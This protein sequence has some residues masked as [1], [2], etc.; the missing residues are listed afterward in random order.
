MDTVAPELLPIKKPW[1]KQWWF[2]VLVIILGLWLVFPWFLQLFGYQPPASNGFTALPGATG[3]P[4]QVVN[5][6][7][8]DDPQIGFSA[9]PVTIVEFGDFECP[10]CKQEAP[11]L[12]QLLSNYPDTIKIIFRDFPVPAIHVN[13]ISAAVAANCAANQGKFWEFHDGLYAGQD[14]LG[15]SLYNSLVQSLKLNTAAFSSCLNSS[16]VVAEIEQDF[17]DGVSAGVRGTP[18]FFVNGHKIEGAIPYDVWV[19]I[20]T[21]AVAEKFSN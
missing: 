17:T 8:V 10:F 14:N 9:A 7:T 19:Q 18:T 11:V 21:A 2:I 6:V 5:M 20:I 16:A 12:K 1:Y 3:E 15:L 13:A 4:T